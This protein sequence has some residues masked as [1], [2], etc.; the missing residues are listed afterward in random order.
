VKPGGNWQI[1]R[2]AL[3]IQ[4]RTFRRKT[5]W[6]VANGVELLAPALATWARRQSV[7]E[8]LP[9]QR[10]KRALILGANHIGDLLYRTASL[11]ALKKGLPHC[12][13][14]YLTAPA[15]AEILA[16]QPSLHAVLPFARSESPLD[17]SHDHRAALR[18]LRFDAA[19]CTNSSSYW[20]ELLLAIRLGI[21]SRVG[22]THKGFSGWVTHPVP[23][24]YPQSFSSYFRDYVAHVTEQ[25]PTWPLRP[26]MYSD[27]DAEDDARAAWQRHG[28]GGNRPVLACF[29]T[30]RQP[31]SVWPPEQFGRTLAHLRRRTSL[32]IALCGAA[33]DRALLDTINRDFDL[34]AAVI[35]GDLGLRPLYC[36]LTKCAAALVS[37]SG[38]RHLANAAGLPVYF[39]RNIRSNRIETG[40]YL[41]TELDLAPPDELVPASRQARVLE[42]IVPES[43]ADAIVDGLRSARCRP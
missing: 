34:D 9:P 4:P 12:D 32:Q 26:R 25:D 11:E 7:G 1:E 40:R 5:N 20:A 27:A 41:E 13:F 19:L 6:V 8:P 39:V 24:R 36:L 23:M 43:V 18:D 28:L 22:Y 2:M 38:P 15:T 33:G 17:L 21:P 37:D 35:A 42:Q 29:V 3:F 31:T 10:W 30:T 16:G 14:Y